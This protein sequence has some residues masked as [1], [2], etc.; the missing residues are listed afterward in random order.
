V[1]FLLRHELL[2]PIFHGWSWQAVVVP[3][4]TPMRMRPY[5]H[6]RQ[7]DAALRIHQAHQAQKKRNSNA[8]TSSH[9]WAPPLRPG[10]VHRRTRRGCEGLRPAHYGQGKAV[11][12]RVW[13]EG[14]QRNRNCGDEPR[15]RRP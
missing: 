14:A 3:S 5:H 13:C 2:T 4:P 10:M 9:P 6:S 11:M 15:N 12:V 8:D 7:P 1:A